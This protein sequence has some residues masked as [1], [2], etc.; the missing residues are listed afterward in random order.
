MV[1]AVRQALA[2]V[3][4]MGEGMAVAEMGGLMA[5]EAKAEAG[6]T[7]LEGHRNATG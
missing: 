2:A 3:A 1:G 6:V 4:V 7:A 5:A